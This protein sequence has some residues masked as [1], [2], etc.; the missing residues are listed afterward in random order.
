MSRFWKA[1]DGRWRQGLVAFILLFLFS[2]AYDFTKEGRTSLS[3]IQD[4]LLVAAAIALAPLEGAESLKGQAKWRSVLHSPR[5]VAGVASFFA[6][7]CVFLL[8]VAR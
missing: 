4:L 7:A 8:R 3:G 5:Y 1:K 6:A 2:A